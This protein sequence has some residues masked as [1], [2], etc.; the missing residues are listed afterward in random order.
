MLGA[1]KSFNMFE[2]SGDYE[3]LESLFR[4]QAIQCDSTTHKSNHGHPISSDANASMPTNLNILLCK[5]KN[6]I[7]FEG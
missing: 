4:F 6:E 3:K 2:T 7:F 5:V 1:T